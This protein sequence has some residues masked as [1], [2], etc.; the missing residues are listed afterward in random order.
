MDKTKKTLQEERHPL[1]CNLNRLM[2][3]I[4]SARDTC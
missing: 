2:Q 3:L 4:L 1:I